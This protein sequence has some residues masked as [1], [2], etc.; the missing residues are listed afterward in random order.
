MYYDYGYGKCTSQ[1]VNPGRVIQLIQI[2]E[3]K[4]NHSYHSSLVL[5]RL[6]DFRIFFLY[7][8]FQSSRVYRFS[9]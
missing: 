7:E 4:I 8:V 5:I 2:Y 3:Q 6:V 1:F 9:S